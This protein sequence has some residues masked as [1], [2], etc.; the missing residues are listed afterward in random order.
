MTEVAAAEAYVVRWLDQIG[1]EQG[2]RGYQAIHPT[3]QAAISREEYLD[4]LEG[5]SA[6]TIRY[7]VMPGTDGDGSGGT[8]F[9]TVAVKVEGGS[10]AFPQAFLDLELTQP[11]V[12]GIEDEGV[13][14]VT[15]AGGGG[16][17]IWRP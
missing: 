7:D 8:M 3:L 13:F 1:S 15:R 6:D 12:V 17:G 2:D 9:Y 5:V 11:L 14:I 16:T 4:A 10:A